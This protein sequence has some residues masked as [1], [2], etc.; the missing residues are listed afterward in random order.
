M[1]A[2]GE[3]PVLLGFLDSDS[4][5]LQLDA[6]STAEALVLLTP[7]VNSHLPAWHDMAL[8][9]LRSSEGYQD[10]VAVVTSTLARDPASLL[11]TEN[12]EIW[13]PLAELSNAT[14]AAL[15]ELSVAEAPPLWLSLDQPLSHKHRSTRPPL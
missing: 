11:S 13:E 15:A 12:E 1:A 2:S 3:V 9:A 10:Y 7:S 5:A 4:D 14:G 8:S 6:R